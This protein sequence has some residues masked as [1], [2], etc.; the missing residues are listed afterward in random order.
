[1]APAARPKK[2]RTPGTG[3]IYQRGSTWWIAYRSEGRQ[4]RETSHSTDQEAAAALLRKRLSA[5]DTARAR[6]SVHV[7]LG[8]LEQ[9]VANDYLANGR[10]NARRLAGIWKRIY[11]VWP[12]TTPTKEVT[13]EKIVAYVAL[14]RATKAASATINRELAQMRRGFRLAVR[15][16]LL[17]S[18]P[19]FSLLREA[20][21]RQ[22]FV[23]RRDLEAILKAMPEYVRPVIEMAYETGWRVCS[24]VLTRQWRH[25]D[26]ESQPG[27][28]RL[29]PGEGKTEEG[30]MFP[31]TRQLRALLEAQLKRS[32]ALQ[33]TLRMRIATVFPRDD[34]APVT[35][36]ELRAAWDR[37]RVAAGRPGAL[38]HDF[39]RTAA[40][41]LSRAGVAR[42]AAMRMIG[43][44]T[45]SM[46][47]RY[48]IVDETTLREAAA[49]IDAGPVINAVFN[50]PNQARKGRK[51]RGA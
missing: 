39:R 47:R 45:E 37:A 50:E 27:W 36:K 32:K 40:R 12:K 29:E 9:L 28:L 34:G 17:A 8:R 19:D 4:T 5:L 13:P 2:R 11:Q 14:R 22:G 51:G 1:V 7:T 10:R 44:K 18:R 46:Y 24:E 30:R 6:P 38:L 33:Q 48:A 41:N 3:H 15:T 23:E 49:R 16:G 42:E 43:H 25:V 21:P 26:M 20:S 31:L 35:E